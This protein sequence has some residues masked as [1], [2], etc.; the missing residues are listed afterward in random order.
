MLN[1]ALRLFLNTFLLLLCL[2]VIPVDAVTEQLTLHFLNVGQADA[3]FIQTPAGQNILVDAGNS[4]DANFIIEYLHKHNVTHI[5]HLVGTHPHADHIGGMATIINTFTIG[6]VYLPRVLHTTKTY[7]NLLLT[8]ASNNLKV[9]PIA[10]DLP[11]SIGAEL[12]AVFIAPIRSYKE[13][14]DNS[15]VLRIEYG[16]TSFLLT[17]D[18]QAEAEA[19]LLQAGLEHADL[20]KVAHHGSA[21]ST[22]SAFLKTV[23]PTYAVISV[24]R[25]NV[26]KLPHPEI[27]QR[28]AK[29]NV[30]V[31]RTDLHGTIIAVSDGNSITMYWEEPYATN[32]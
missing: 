13:I 22:T 28:L 27:V 3:I 21:T 14:N 4:S 24:G 32:Y 18:A 5:D 7:E 11:L 31:Y 26:Y 30:I 9:T 6:K 1:R 16:D 8:I 15:A 25:N 20:L 19:D 12:T 2:L 23:R 29:S 10:A 17:G